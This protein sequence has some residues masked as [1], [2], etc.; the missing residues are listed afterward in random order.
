MYVILVYDADARRGP[1]LLKLCRQYLHWVQNS[2]FE[3]EI[4]PAAL[5]ELKLRAEEVLEGD[6]SLIVFHSRSAQWLE[7]E[8][9]GKERSGTGNIL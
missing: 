7:K 3:G 8:I 1:R 4:T 6:D 5:R 9:L 2:V